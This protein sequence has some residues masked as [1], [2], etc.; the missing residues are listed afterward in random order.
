MNLIVPLLLASVLL[1]VDSGD[2]VAL[3][4]QCMGNSDCGDANAMCDSVCKCKTDYAE[5]D[6]LCRL[7]GGKSC[8]ADENCVSLKCEAQEGGD[9]KCSSG[10]SAASSLILMI[11]TLVIARFL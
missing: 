8:T 2:V 11:V 1:Q 7:V 5:K 3:N 10:T 4:E 9:K 6:D